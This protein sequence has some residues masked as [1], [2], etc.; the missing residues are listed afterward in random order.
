MVKFTGYLC[1]LSFL[2]MFVKLLSRTMKLKKAD[3]FIMKLHVPASGVFCIALLVHLVLN[4][5]FFKTGAAAAYLLGAAAAIV[6]LLL[7]TLCH[8]MKDPKAKFRWHRILA[9]TMLLLIICHYIF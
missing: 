8:T 6:S 3:K 5:I 9:V 2:L 4:L 1:V 7:I